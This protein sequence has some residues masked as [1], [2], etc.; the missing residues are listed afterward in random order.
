MHRS[1]KFFPVALLSFA[2]LFAANHVAAQ[3]PWPSKPITILV[4]YASGGL[5]DLLARVIGEKLHTRLGQPVVVDIKSGA[6]A[7]IAT[8][9]LARAKP[10]GYTFGIVTSNHATNPSLM[11]NLAYTDEDF[12]AVSLLAKMHMVLV[13][14][15]RATSARDLTSFLAEGKANPDGILYA[16]A[17]S[18]NMTHMS[19]ELLADLTG[20]PFT[21]VPYRGGGAA[22]MD[23]MG[24]QVPS[25]FVGVQTLLAQLQGEAEKLLHPLAV[26]SQTRLDT[27][28]DVPTFSE[29]GYPELV[30]SEWQALIAPAG[31]PIEIINTMSAHIQEILQLP[32]VRQRLPGVVLQGSTPEAL[33][34]FMQAETRRWS[35]LLAQRQAGKN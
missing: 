25:Q 8:A 2:S 34:A 32:D 16:S 6:S 28:P 31:T 10:D 15:T 26:A 27:L 22:I 5:S 19:G 24:G 23:L 29:L 18:G 30:I 33:Q 35:T 9:A 14:S 12:S 13:V 20:Q 11:H 3:T 1:Y 7:S 4:G 17:G 21:Q